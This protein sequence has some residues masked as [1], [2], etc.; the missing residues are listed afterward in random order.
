MFSIIAAVGKNR[1]IGRKG[2]LVFHLH[3]DMKYFKEMTMGQAVLM[4]RKTWDSLGRK[5]L[6]GRMNLVVSHQPMPQADATVM[7]LPE[8]VAYHMMDEFEEIFIIG[9]ASLYRQMM[10]VVDTLYLTEI[11]A[12]AP[13]ADSFFPEFD[14]SQF[15]K[16]VIKKGSENGID[17]VFARYDRMY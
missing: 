13:G 14:K 17:Y 7:D 2:E 12:E 3:E 16:T 1:E 11:D 15:L 10:P 9:G 4:G 6:P 8:L 5:K